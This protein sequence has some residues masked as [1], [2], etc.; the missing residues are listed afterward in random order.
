MK[1]SRVLLAI[2]LTPLMLGNAPAPWWACE[3]RHPGDHCEPYHHWSDDEH[4]CWHEH[5]HDG[6]CAVQHDCVDDPRTRVD[7]CLYCRAD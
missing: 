5:H 7:E 2:L 6:V 3:D 1:A 4:A